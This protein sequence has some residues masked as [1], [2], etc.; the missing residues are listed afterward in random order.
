[1]LLDGFG[2]TDLICEGFSRGLKGIWRFLWFLGGQNVVKC[3]VNV[4][5]K[6]RVFGWRVGGHVFCI[7]FP[8]DMGESGW[9]A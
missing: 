4:V 6:Q 1:M 2:M 8:K 3:V 5:R 7:Y 9:A